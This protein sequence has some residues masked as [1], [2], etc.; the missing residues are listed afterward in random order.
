MTE[1]YLCIFQ[2]PKMGKNWYVTGDGNWDVEAVER[3][4]HVRVFCKGLM[5]NEL[6]TLFAACVGLYVRLKKK[7]TSTLT[8]YHVIE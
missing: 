7:K 3:M 5:I 6:T 8:L 1:P 4:K 2:I